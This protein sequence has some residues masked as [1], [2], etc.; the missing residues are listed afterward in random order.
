MGKPRAQSWHSGEAEFENGTCQL[1]GLQP[2]CRQLAGQQIVYL[3]AEGGDWADAER[4][5]SLSPSLRQAGKVGRNDV[6]VEPM[7]PRKCRVA[8]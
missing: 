8:A 5:N 1:Q 3:H 4:L 2:A 6:N 7:L